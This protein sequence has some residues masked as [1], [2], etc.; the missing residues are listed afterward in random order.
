[1]YLNID[2]LPGLSQQLRNPASLL[3]NL[4]HSVLR[5]GLPRSGNIA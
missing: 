1:M 2:T 3:G 5:H 4:L